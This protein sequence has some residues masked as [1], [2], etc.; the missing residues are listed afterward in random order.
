MS[1]I[2]IKDVYVITDQAEGNKSRWLKIGVAFLNKDSSLNVILDALPVS[3]KIH[4]RDRD[5]KTEA[6][7]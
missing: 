2:K 6:E 7:K 1:T 4:I 3:G 5:L